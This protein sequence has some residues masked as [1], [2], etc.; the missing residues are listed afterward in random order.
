VGLTRAY[1]GVEKHEDK[2]ETGTDV[3]RLWFLDHYSGVDEARRN[4]EDPS[5]LQSGVPMN[6]A[7][8]KRGRCLLILG[9]GSCDF[10]D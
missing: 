3:D 1:R 8:V 10:D 9:D 6:H 7:D 4:W 2:S 5:E